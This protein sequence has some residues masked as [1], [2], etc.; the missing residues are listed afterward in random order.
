MKPRTRNES[1]EAGKRTSARVV[2]AA[3]KRETT[4]PPEPQNGKPLRDILATERAAYREMV[5]ELAEQ[6]VAV[7][8]VPEAQ[9][10]PPSGCRRRRPA[11][12]VDDYDGRSR[13]QVEGKRSTDLT[14]VK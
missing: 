6:E 7:A 10:S 11:P 8:P 1:G 14:K 13:E 5:S 2:A 4:A 9:E 12:G 3:P